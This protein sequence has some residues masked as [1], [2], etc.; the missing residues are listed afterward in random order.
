[1]KV[2]ILL[3]VLTLSTITTNAQIVSGPPNYLNGP[4]YTYCDALAHEPVNTAVTYG[5]FRGRGLVESDCNNGGN[6]F[7]GNTVKIGGWNYG[8]I[9]W[10]DWSADPLA[11]QKLSVWTSS[12]W[13]EP[14]T[15][16]YDT[17][18]LRVISITSPSFP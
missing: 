11:G 1:M 15:V 6:N 3:I 7:Y 17:D 14:L 10:Y 8:L 2:L 13:S 5:F 16:T 12:P 18:T 9:Y 4:A